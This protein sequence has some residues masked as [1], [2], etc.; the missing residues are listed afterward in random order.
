MTKQITK[1]LLNVFKDAITE[2][3]S[4]L[5][6][7]F[8]LENKFTAPIEGTKNGKVPFVGTIENQGDVMAFRFH[9]TG[10]EFKV[11]G[12]VLDFN[13]V[14]EASDFNIS[15]GPYEFKK[16]VQTLMGASTFLAKEEKEVAVSL[17]KILPIEGLSFKL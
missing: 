11:N 9:G 13:Y 8:Q 5:I 6:E 10:C 7:H 3:N 12:L 4:A 15:F 16:F 2:W 14:F 17:S 1:L